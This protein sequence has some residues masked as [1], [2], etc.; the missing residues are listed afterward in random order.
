MSIIYL[1]IYT[2]VSGRGWAFSENRNAQ[3]NASSNGRQWGEDWAFP[4]QKCNV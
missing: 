1:L 2:I 4:D 3:H